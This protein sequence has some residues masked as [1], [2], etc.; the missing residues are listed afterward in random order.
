MQ[1]T[2]KDV[3]REYMLYLL[4]NMYFFSDSC[5]SDHFFDETFVRAVDLLGLR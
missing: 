5:G 4:Q 3:E 2:E 1:N